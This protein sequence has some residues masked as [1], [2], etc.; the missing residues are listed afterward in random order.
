MKIALLVSGNAEKALAVY[1]FFKEGN[2]ID[3]DCLITDIPDSKVIEPF[4]AGG[5]ETFSFPMSEWETNSEKIAD[6]LKNRNVQLVCVDNFSYP[7]NDQFRSR[8]DSHAV[9]SLLEGNAG[10]NQVVE[11]MKMVSEAEERK[12]KGITTPENATQEE[13]WA[14][15][16][17]INYN[18]DESR[19]IPEPEPETISTAHTNVPPPY[20]EGSDR[21]QPSRNSN[22]ESTSMPDTYLIWAVVVTVLCCLI[23]GIIAIVNAASVST[24]YYNGDIEG[25]ERASRRTQIWIIISIVCGLVWNTIYVPL[26]LITGL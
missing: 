6:F 15:T 10:A 13:E 8:F 24:R 11:A 20:P 5:V 4:T 19:H 17:H 23:P 3:I 18:P 26:M 2:R 9:V 1:N 22:R 14:Q 21:I 25:A 16:L 7:L 12:S